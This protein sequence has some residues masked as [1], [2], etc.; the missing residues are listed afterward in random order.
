MFGSISNW[1]NENKPNIAM[2]NV[3]MPTINMPNIAMPNMPNMPNLNMPKMPEFLGGKKAEGAEGEQVE[4]SVEGG[5][6]A[7]APAAAND[8]TEPKETQPNDAAA[9]NAGQPGDE[10]SSEKPAGESSDPSFDPSKAFGAAKEIGSNIGSNIGNM[11]FSMG[12]QVESFGKNASSNVMKTAT[13]IKDVIEKKTII[14]DFN[15]ENEKFVTDKKVQQRREDAALPPWVGYAEE[16]ILKEQILSLSQDSRNFLKSPPVGVDFQFDFNLAYPV[17]MVTLEEDSNLK[18]MR[19]KLVPKHI[20]EEGF[21]RNYF[22]R[23]SLVKQSIQLDQ[24]NNE[25]NISAPATPNDARD[26][27]YNYNNNS[28]SVDQPQQPSSGAANE[29]VSDYYEHDAIN[30]EEIRS[31]LKQL[32]LDS[33]KPTSSSGGDDLED[34]DKELPEDIDSISA[35]ELEK[36]INQMIGSNNK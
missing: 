11:F 22:Y 17:A 10:N 3:N 27:S 36:E 9:A 21:W 25:N 19:F 31:D 16:E 6:T 8:T 18:D 23:V 28:G 24:M 1:I 13:Q 32:K 30:D 35:E 29:F 34:W 20:N 7:S 33:K 26:K 2:P 5:E 4:Q 12:K 15:K 14:G